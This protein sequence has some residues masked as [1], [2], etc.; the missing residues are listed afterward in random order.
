MVEEK[1]I[2]KKIEILEG[3]ENTIMNL[4]KNKTMT[5]EEIEEELGNIMKGQE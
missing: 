1:K 3:Q 5:L 4:R 2:S